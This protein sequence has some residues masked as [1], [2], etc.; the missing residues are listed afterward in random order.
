MDVGVYSTRAV[1]E[2]RS[3]TLIELFVSPEMSA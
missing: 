2:Y 3:D 1:P